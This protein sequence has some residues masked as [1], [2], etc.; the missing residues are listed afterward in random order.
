MSLR[1]FTKLATI[2]WAAGSN[3]GIEHMLPAAAIMRKEEQCKA[4]EPS[5]L[6]YV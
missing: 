6:S 2:T 3:A 5:G 4:T 1:D